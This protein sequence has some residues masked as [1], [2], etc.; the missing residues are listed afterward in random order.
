MENPPETAGFD[1]SVARKTN[2]PYFPVSGVDERE[3]SWAMAWD[4]L[5]M[6][7]NLSDENTGA[8]CALYER[9]YIVKPNDSPDVEPTWA[10]A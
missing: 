7:G 8:I 4:V 1:Y 5:D 10:A 2:Q 6:F 9:F 3:I